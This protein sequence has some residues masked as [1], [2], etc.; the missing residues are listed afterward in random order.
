MDA[1]LKTL[2]DK[3]DMGDWEKI[4]KLAESLKL[5]GDPQSELA[6]NAG[7]LD[8]Q[9]IADQLVKIRSVRGSNESFFTRATELAVLVMFGG[10]PITIDLNAAHLESAPTTP[11]WWPP[12]TKECLCA[13]EKALETKKLPAD[14]A[15]AMTLARRI[16]VDRLLAAFQPADPLT[17]VS[18]P[19]SN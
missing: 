12:S 3:I 19:E 16:K 6:R 11:R 9:E 15:R 17:P 13:V 14:V 10:L 2:L 4:P 7:M 8:P 1:E 5:R 18:P